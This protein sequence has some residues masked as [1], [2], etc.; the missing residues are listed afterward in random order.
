MAKAK[1]EKIKWSESL[2]CVK[3]DLKPVFDS[4]PLLDEW[5]DVQNNL[6][7]NE[8]NSLEELRDELAQNVSFWNEEELK[9]NFLAFILRMA[10]YNRSK[11]YR[12]Y[13][14][15]ELSAT[16]KGFDLL[17]KADFMISKGLG[18][19]YEAPY[20]CFHEFKR[21]KNADDPIAQVL[22]AM[23]IAQEKNQNGKPIYGCYIMGAS[24][25]F[26]IMI[27]DTYVQMTDP[28]SA[29]NR[30][31]LQKI[32]LILRKFKVILETQLKD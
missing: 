7:Q 16:I 5:L 22:L 6:T 10:E 11:Y 30:L 13:L 28:L 27:G 20:F 19:V 2:I 29:T 1:K 15:R 25:Y 31:D 24:W 9:I 14:D 8:I 26:M 18:D 32:L 17:T 3:F 21:K 23:L 4:H 12:T